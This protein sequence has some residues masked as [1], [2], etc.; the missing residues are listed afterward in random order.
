MA[1]TIGFIIGGVAGMVIGLV[2]GTAFYTVLKLVS[3]GKSPAER[4]LDYILER[5]DFS[6]TEP[7][8]SDLC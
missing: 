5:D 6:T 7:A 3:S 4:L 2:A 8:S 1:G